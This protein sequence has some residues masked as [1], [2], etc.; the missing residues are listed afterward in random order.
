MKSNIENRRGIKLYV[1]ENLCE[2]FLLKLLEWSSGL[3]V[4]G[5]KSI[6]WLENCM[7]IVVWLVWVF[8]LK[9]V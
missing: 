3:G 6:M 4:V 1:F 9:V 7:C 2:V 5:Y 8:L